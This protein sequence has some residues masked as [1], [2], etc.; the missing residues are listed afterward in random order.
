MTLALCR[1]GGHQTTAAIMLTSMALLR[2]LPNVY[3]FP[4]LL[5]LP[6]TFALCHSKTA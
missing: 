4:K 2:D 3:D 1:L 5:P 6:K